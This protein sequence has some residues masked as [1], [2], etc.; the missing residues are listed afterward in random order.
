MTADTPVLRLPLMFLVL[1]L[2]TP[3]AMAQT[4]PWPTDPPPTA[5]APAATAAPAPMIGAPTAAPAPMA[6]SPMGAPRPMSGPPDAAQ[7]DCMTQF[8]H[9]RADVERLRAVLDKVAGSS[10]SKSEK[11]A[12]REDVCKAITHYSAAE[13]KWTK[14]IVDNTARCGIPPDFGK[15]ASAGHAKTESVRKNICSAGPAGGGQPATP[16]LS[17]A[18]GTS[19][20]PLPS[21][22]NSTR[23]TFDTLTG[24]AIKR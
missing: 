2:S 18:L 12:S 17:D 8:N 3:A 14:F 16:S 4:L 23:G 10:R 6:G 20:Q 24:S 21:D 13:G 15:Q 1:A 11:K 7:Q 9:L 22:A 5:G 19:R